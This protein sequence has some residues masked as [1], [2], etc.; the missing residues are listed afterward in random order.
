[1]RWLH[2]HQEVRYALAIVIADVAVVASGPAVGT[3]LSGWVDEAI[4]ITVRHL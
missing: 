3:G 4:L 2:G 1:M